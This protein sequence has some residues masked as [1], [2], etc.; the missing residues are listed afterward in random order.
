MFDQ[1]TIAQLSKLKKDILASKDIAEGT[2]TG[3]AGRYGFVKLD[4]GRS[5]FLNPEKMMRLLP[6]DRV[7]V[8]VVKNDKDQ[9]EGELEKLVSSELTRFVGRYKVKGNAHFVLPE[10]QTRWIFLP[11]QFRAKCKEDDLVLAEIVHH[12]YEDGKAAAKILQRIGADGEDYLHQNLVTARFNLYR[13]WSKD[14]QKQVITC[15]Q[16][17]TEADGE[18]LDSI[19]FITIDSA[20]TKDMDDALY[21]EVLEDGWRLWVAIADPASCISPGSPIAKS[22]K[23]HGQS[24]YLPGTTLAML[25]EKLAT[26]TFSLLPDQIRPVLVCRIEIKADGS[27]GEFDFRRA[28]IRS[29][30]KLS[31]IGVAEYLQDN[32]QAEG[33]TPE[34]GAV[35]RELDRLAKVRFEYRQLHNLIFPDQIEYDYHINKQGLIESVSVRNRNAAHRLVEEAMV[36]TNLCAGQ[37]LSAHHTGIF[38]VNGGFRKERLGEVKAL[39]REAFDAGRNYDDIAELDGYLKL[40]KELDQSAEHRPLLP[41]LKRM[42]QPTELSSMAQPHMG[43]GFAA[44]APITSPIRRFADLANHWSIHQILDG[45]KVQTMPD[46][47]LELLCESVANGRQ[48]VRQLEQT[49]WVLYL[50]DRLGLEDKGVIRI[51]TQQGFGV[52][53]LQTGIEGFVQFSKKSQKVFDAKRMT[54]TVDDAHFAL[55]QEVAVRVAAVDLEKRRVKLTLLD[56][57]KTEVASEEEVA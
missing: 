6:G 47:P 53:L 11:H 30:A 7:K 39:L 10:G 2:V 13:Y 34:I 8:N 21:A 52:R 56:S 50:K 37:Y 51:V 25:P 16:K 41:A 45:A 19:P 57:S 33:L 54:L 14:A 27:V 17:A 40:L 43:M 1:D 49:L 26:E 24:V 3:S 20:S 32:D 46:G 9:L 22:A 55:E 36:V 29:R 44:Y 4:D 42:M 38:S 5:V 35:L 28:K 31:Y 23:F 48:A 15:Q 12:P 18:D